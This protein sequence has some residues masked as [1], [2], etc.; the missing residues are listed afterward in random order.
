MT[1]T[2]EI[3]LLELTVI[4]AEAEPLTFAEAAKE[5]L[6]RGLPPE[7]VTR[8]EDLWEKTKIIGGEVIAVGKL[9]VKK[10]V[11]FFLAN[12]GLAISLAIGAAVGAL[13][14]SS[15]PFIGAML[16][17]LVAILVTLYGYN[18]QSGGRESL[19]FSTMKL[20]TEFFRLLI[21]IFQVVVGYVK[22]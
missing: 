15:I 3:A 17:P 13:V 2:A 5:L 7:L 4:N 14:S 11:D 9:I 6:N 22:N 16:A 21:E 20:A 18:V 19:L 12:P 1:I 8:L 10:I